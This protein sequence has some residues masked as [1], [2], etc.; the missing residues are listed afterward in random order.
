MVDVTNLRAAGALHIRTF[1]IYRGDERIEVVAVLVAGG[2]NGHPRPHHV[3]VGV[4][5]A[6]LVA[7][8]GEQPLVHVAVI[9]IVFQTLPTRSAS[10][11]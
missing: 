6:G 8:R 3:V 1:H 4:E 11:T 7:P 2:D 9:G 5:D 10:K